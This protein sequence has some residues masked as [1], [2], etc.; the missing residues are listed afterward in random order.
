[1]S[2]LPLKSYLTV[3]VTSQDTQSVR[4]TEQSD[5]SITYLSPLSLTPEQQNRWL[6]L[7]KPEY[8]LPCHLIHHDHDHQSLRATDV[9]TQPSWPLQLVRPRSR[10]AK[11]VWYH[12]I[13]ASLDCCLPAGLYALNTAHC[14]FIFICVSWSVSVVVFVGSKPLSLYNGDKSQLCQPQLVPSSYTQGAAHIGGCF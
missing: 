5:S 7:V 9:T 11:I 3:R 8:P 1:M 14:A 2:P 4:A 6:G 12:R 13:L 10:F